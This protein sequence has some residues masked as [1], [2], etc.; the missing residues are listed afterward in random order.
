MP[1]ANV[2]FQEWDVDGGN[3]A[4]SS[5]EYARSVAP[6]VSRRQTIQESET[7]A[8]VAK[9]EA[10]LKQLVR[11][12]PNWDSYG[13]RPVSERFAGITLGLLDG[14]MRDT[15]PLPSIVPTNT[16]RV[17]LEWH[18]KGI[19]LEVEIIS[20]ILV[21]VS[22]EDQR[23]GNEWERDLNVVDLADLYQAVSTLSTR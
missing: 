11:L 15:T 10:R 20:P 12:T 13:A 18:T 7:S 9:A 4:T 3:V 2:R 22:F 1:A 6:R 16:G 23:T 8:W 21:H 14:L 17:Q 19:D 5:R